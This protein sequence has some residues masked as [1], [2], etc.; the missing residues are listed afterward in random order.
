[1]N[2][3][4]LPLKNWQPAPS[5]SR[6]L[7]LICN[8]FEFLASWL[9]GEREKLKKST[10]GAAADNKNDRKI[11][12]RIIALG[13]SF[14]LLNI[15]ASMKPFSWRFHCRR[16]PP[17][18]KKIHSFG[19]EQ[20][21]FEGSNQKNRKKPWLFLKKKRLVDHKKKLLRHFAREI[22]PLRGILAWL[23]YYY[24]SYIVFFP[25]KCIL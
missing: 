1:M 16:F 20:T 12:Y 21:K 7:E 11:Y 5:S 6:K 15:F 14:T 2:R 17:L 22:D 4:L 25:S 9:W 10:L 8:K 19:I 13:H 24:T 3:T 23:H 18:I